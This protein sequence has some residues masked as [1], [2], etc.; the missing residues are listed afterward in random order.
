MAVLASSAMAQ[1]SQEQVNRNA[2]DAMRNEE[3]IRNSNSGPSAAQ[4]REQQ[5]RA[6]AEWQAREDA[7]QAKIANY[8]ATPYYGTL[9][10]Q[11]NTNHI[12][13]GGGGYITKEM[14]EKKSA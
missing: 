13:W 4:I 6:Q 2:I 9:I 1:F 12:G 7:I 5:R 8:R 11:G 14:A 10:T 3:L